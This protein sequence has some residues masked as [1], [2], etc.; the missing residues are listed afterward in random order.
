MFCRICQREGSEKK[1]P[2]CKKPCK[3]V[4]RIFHDLRRSFCKNVDEA[5]VSRDVAMSI[6]GHKT[7]DTYSRYNTC[8]VKRKRKALELVQEFREAQAEQESNVVAMR[9]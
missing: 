3:Y 2:D 1:C 5:N 8:D 9:R 6:S 4:G 7:Q